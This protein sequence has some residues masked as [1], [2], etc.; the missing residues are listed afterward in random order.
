LT[1]VIPFDDVVREKRLFIYEK[2]DKKTNGPSS[3]W[4]FHCPDH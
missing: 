1:K 3:F 4:V 2:R